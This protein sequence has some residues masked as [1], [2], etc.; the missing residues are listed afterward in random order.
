LSVKRDAEDGILT[1]RISKTAFGSKSTFAALPYFDSK[2]VLEIRSV[3][4]QSSASRLTGSW[5][6]GSAYRQNGFLI[7]RI[8]MSWSKAVSS[9][10]SVTIR[11][12]PMPAST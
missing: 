9:E 1:E 8:R 10:Y 11:H 4:I 6:A 7:G 5:H 3:R 12:A 2:A